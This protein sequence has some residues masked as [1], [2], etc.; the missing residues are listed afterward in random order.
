VC[1]VEDYPRILKRFL[2]QHPAAAFAVITGE[3]A[4][5]AR[6]LG[7]KANCIGYEPELDTQS[8]NTKGNWKDLD[9]IRP[10]GT[11]RGGMACESKRSISPPW[12]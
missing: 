11:S 3:F 8:Y 9:L 12:M 4:I 5:V 6:S 2:Q 10:L 7:M 1:A